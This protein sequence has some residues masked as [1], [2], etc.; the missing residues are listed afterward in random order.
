MMTDEEK[1]QGE[2]VGKKPYFHFPK[3]MSETEEEPSGWQAAHQMR[4]TKEGQVTFLDHSSE[5]SS[6]SIDVTL[7]KAL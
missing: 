1:C 3:V 4:G 5:G 6:F 2:T 7:C